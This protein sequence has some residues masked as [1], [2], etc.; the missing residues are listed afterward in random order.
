VVTANQQVLTVAVSAYCAAY[1]KELTKLPALLRTPKA[2][3]F[4]QASRR[5]RELNCRPCMTS[6]RPCQLPRTAARPGVAWSSTVAGG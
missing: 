6:A 3:P 1:A 4:R 5:G 2:Q